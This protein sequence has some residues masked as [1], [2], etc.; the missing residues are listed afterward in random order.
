MIE[1]TFPLLGVAFVALVVLPAFALLAK[2]GLVMLERDEVGGP[3]HGLN[4]RYVLLSG[5]SVLPIAW[6]LSAGL[7]Q[8]ESGTSAHACLFD[9]ETSELC[10]EPGFFSLVLAVFVVAS[11]FGT[12]WRH[13]AAR[14]SSSDAAHALLRRL[15]RIASNDPVLASLRGRIV[16][17]DDHGFAL[18][19]HG[20]LRPRVF[21]GT[22]FAGRVSDE[23]LASA[24]GHE[25]QHVRALDPLR[26]LILRVALG[27]NPVGRALLEPHFARWQAAREAHCDREAVI[28]GAAPLPLADAIVIAARPGAREPVA[29]GARDTAVLKFRIGMLLAFSEQAPTRCCHQGLSTFPVAMV[30]LLVAL[31]LPHHTGTAVL[32]LLH[33]S[34]E[35]ALTYFWR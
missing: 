7:H 12:M 29:L 1:A 4:L 34:T 6:L 14:A 24:L 25:A 18:G 17:T 16:V 9:H 13:R 35:R 31:L 28:L 2:V 22:A 20:L 11:S 30:L 27:V 33:T 26:Y 8:A 15:D 32:D 19:T 10:L 23:M 21:V 3:L 5:S